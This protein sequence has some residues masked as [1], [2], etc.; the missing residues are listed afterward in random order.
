MHEDVS[1][2]QSRVVDES[3]KATNRA[4]ADF[5]AKIKQFFGFWGAFSVFRVISRNIWVRFEKLGE[6]SDFLVVTAAFAEVDLVYARST[7]TLGTFWEVVF[8]WLSQRSDVL[9][10]RSSS[11]RATRN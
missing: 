3:H 2:L 10:F 5:T 4:S 9:M 1:Q 11:E 6:I 8:G 7:G